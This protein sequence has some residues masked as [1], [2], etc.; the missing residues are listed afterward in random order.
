MIIK[1]FFVDVQ[2]DI[3]TD[4]RINSCREKKFSNSDSQWVLWKLSNRMSTV[5]KFP[6]STLKISWWKS[7]YGKQ[8]PI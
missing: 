4:F 8:K 1:Y 2:S 5:Q 3:S 6:D 7:L